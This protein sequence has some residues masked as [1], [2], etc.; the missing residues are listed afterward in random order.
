MVVLRPGGQL[1]P[2]VAQEPAAAQ[3]QVQDD[4][5]AARSVHDLLPQ[6]Q[7]AAV[8]VPLAARPLVRAARPAQEGSAACHVVHARNCRDV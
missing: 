1:Q 6:P 7:A 2:V 8:G 5:V 3:L 4:L